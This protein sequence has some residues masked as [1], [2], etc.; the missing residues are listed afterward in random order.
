MQPSPIAPKLR[1]SQVSSSAPLK[2]QLD[3]T[4]TVL[5]EQKETKD[6]SSLQPMEGSMSL[7]YIT[8]KEMLADLVDLL[9]GNAPVILQLNNRFFSLCIIPQDVHNAAAHLNP[10]PNERATRLI[11]SLLTIIQTHSNPNS[12]FSSLITSLQ[13]VGL[14]DMAS[15]LIEKL[16]KCNII[17]TNHHLFY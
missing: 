9:A 13:K 6:P 17:Q 4:A 1:Q 7:E 2:P 14:N 15:K 10:T 11:N 12:V 8:M 3:P 5:Q 16:S